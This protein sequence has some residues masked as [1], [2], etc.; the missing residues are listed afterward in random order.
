MVTDDYAKYM[1]QKSLGVAWIR[2]PESLSQIANLL[3]NLHITKWRIFD[4][5]PSHSKLVI[6]GEDGGQAVCLICHITKHIN[7]GV[8]ISKPSFTFEKREDDYLTLIMNDGEKCH[9]V[10]CSNVDVRPLDTRE[11]G[12]IGV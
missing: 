1:M 12:R 11:A 3:N 8:Y 4:Y 2:E 5:F 9:E 10:I 7:C 6:G